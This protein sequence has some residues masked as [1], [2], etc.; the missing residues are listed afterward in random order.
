MTRNAIPQVEGNTAISQ[1]HGNTHM[2]L[3]GRISMLTPLVL[4]LC[5]HFRNI[6]QQFAFRPAVKPFDRKTKHSGHH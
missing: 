6:L 3:I 2:L 1:V 5:L 4:I